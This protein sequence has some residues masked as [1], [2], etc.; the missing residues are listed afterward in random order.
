MK[1]AYEV[2]GVTKESTDAEIK[3][4]YRKLALKYHP[5][6]N[7][8]NK[9]SEDKFKEAAGAFE[10]IG[11]AERRER[12]NRTQSGQADSFGFDFGD[13]FGGGNFADIFDSVFGQTWGNAAGKG[14]NYS[15]EIS[16]TLRD[17]YFGDTK[18]LDIDGSIITLNIKPGTVDGQ[19]VVF[20][21]YGQMGARAAGD[22]HLK[23]HVLPDLEYNFVRH[24]DN[25][26]LDV[27]VDIFTALLGGTIEVNTFEGK[28]PVHIPIGIQNSQI[29]SV[30]GRG[31]PMYNMASAQGD[32][33][34]K[35]RIIMP[36]NLTAEEIGKIYE[37]KEIND[38]KLT[39]A[40]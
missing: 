3:K 12:Y 6:K 33:L 14:S 25:L 24:Q 18:R 20:P 8:D 17:A 15:A 39:H 26:F 38:K 28:L 35:I 13:I 27:D 1:N 32:L 9:E 23:I 29:I 7:P 21:G 30:A 19:K 11:S 10:C 31:M 22:L 34:L 5:D 37:L 36:N 2:L 16:I 4:A 40:T